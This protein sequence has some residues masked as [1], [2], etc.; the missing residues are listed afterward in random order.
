MFDFLMSD[1]FQLVRFNYLSI[2]GT[3]AQKSDIKKS[4]IRHT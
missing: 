4:D 3:V 2:A 1:L